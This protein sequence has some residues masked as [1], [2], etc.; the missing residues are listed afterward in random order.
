[1]P[2]SGM[3]FLIDVCRND[4]KIIR[5]RD[6]EIFAAMRLPDRTQN[7][8]RPKLASGLFAVILHILRI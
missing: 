4:Q 6:S 8:K 3:R 1:M 7:M 2:L 5:N